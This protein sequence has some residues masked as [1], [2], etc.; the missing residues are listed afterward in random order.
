M[1]CS[2]MGEQNEG[3]RWSMS[4][5]NSI[6]LFPCVFIRLYTAVHKDLHTGQHLPLD[7]F[8][9]LDIKALIPAYVN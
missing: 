4:G 2:G 6:S 9:L 8:E 1:C 3:E 7:L 5:I